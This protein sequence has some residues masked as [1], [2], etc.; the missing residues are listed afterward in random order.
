MIM[1]L[2]CIRKHAS[3]PSSASGTRC[4]A[5]AT[6]PPGGGHHVEMPRL[7][8]TTRPGHGIRALL[9]T[10]VIAAAA[11]AGG[12]P[13]GAW[14][15]VTGQRA[16][17]SVLNRAGTTI[18]SVD[19]LPLSDKTARVRPGVHTLTVQWQPN[20]GLRTSD[21]VLRLDMKPCRRYYVHAQFASPGSTLWQPVVERAEEIAGC[22]VPAALLPP[23]EDAR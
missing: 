15:E 21:R 2:V 19:G 7:P 11:P 22:R 3:N 12:A 14:S 1:V 10:A 23:A 4:S 17:K 8:N 13:E 5:G 16:A 18:K 6:R 20:K 9:V